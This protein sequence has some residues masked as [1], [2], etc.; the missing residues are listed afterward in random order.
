MDDGR[1][2]GNRAD[3]WGADFAA[4]GFGLHLNGGTGCFRVDYKFKW[5]ALASFRER[6]LRRN[7]AQAGAT[8]CKP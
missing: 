6:R 8:I 4:Q 7:P 1:G 2:R 3:G 5:R